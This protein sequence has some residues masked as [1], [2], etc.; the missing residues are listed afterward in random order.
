V[1]GGYF[2]VEVVLYGMGEAFVELVPNM[3]QGLVGGVIGVPLYMTVR[4]A[5]PPLSRYRG[6]M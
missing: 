4:K 6:P 3:I 1:T 2:L 5:Y